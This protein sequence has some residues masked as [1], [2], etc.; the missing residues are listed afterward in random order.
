VDWNRF[1][2]LGVIK[3]NQYNATADLDGYIK[4]IE[5]LF[6]REHYSN[7]RSLKF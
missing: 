4:A 3:K 1:L 6:S 5:E 7:L 2:Q